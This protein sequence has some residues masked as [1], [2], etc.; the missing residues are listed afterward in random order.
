M[1]AE[2]TFPKSDGDI[3]YASEANDFQFCYSAQYEDLAEVSY[4]G[5]SAKTLQTLQTVTIGGGFSGVRLVFLTFDYREQNGVGPVNI[6]GMVDI[7]ASLNAINSV[8]TSGIGG[9]ITNGSASFIAHAGNDGMFSSSYSVPLIISNGDVIRIKMLSNQDY[10]N[11]YVSNLRIWS[12]SPDT[13]F[14]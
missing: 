3:L 14:T 8:S 2:G 9:D 10:V 1:T 7:N 4:T 5:G 12:T 11:L 6:Y 13:T